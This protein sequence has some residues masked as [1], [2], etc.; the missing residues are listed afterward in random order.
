VEA[1]VLESVA[2]R[3]LAMMTISPYIIQGIEEALQASSTNSKVLPCSLPFD[4]TASYVWSEQEGR[5][6][7]FGGR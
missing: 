1:G 5:C 2:R 6:G 3:N 4:I 7:E